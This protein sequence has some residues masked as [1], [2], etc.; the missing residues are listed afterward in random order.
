MLYLA[1]LV[2]TSRAYS[3]VAVL[4]FLI[5]VASP[6]VEHGLQGVKTS[7]VVTTRLQSTGPIV[8]THGLS[9]SEAYGI[10]PDQRLNLCLLH[11]QADSLP[12]SHQGN[13]LF[14][15]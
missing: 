7:V 13:P 14:L 11:L 5:G 6:V 4:R 1:F 9:C 10:F 12:L 15:F 2:M 8:V 3:P